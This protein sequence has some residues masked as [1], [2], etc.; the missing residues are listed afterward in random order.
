MKELITPLTQT[1]LNK[2]GE[3][4]EN[5]SKQLGQKY[6]EITGSGGGDAEHDEIAM[7][8]LD[9]WDQARRQLVEFKGSYGLAE[10]FEAPKQN[11]KVE[12]GHRVEV[13]FAGDEND[14]AYA[15]IVTP[16]NL[17]VLSDLQKVDGSKAFDNE[18][19]MI[20]SS[21]SPLGS[22]LLGHKR[23]ESA[24]VTVIEKGK[25]NRS[26]QVKVGQISSA[27]IFE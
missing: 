4:L 10:V 24:N 2:K 18:T 21:E 14:K 19:E 12:I 5:A 27:Q 23:G 26:F 1:L 6:G 22:A 15:T 20:V 16:I 13:F 25:A 11:D 9:E 8:V 7:R 17:S 3:E